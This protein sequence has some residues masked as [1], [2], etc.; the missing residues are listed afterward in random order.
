MTHHFRHLLA[1]FAR[2]MFGLM[3]FTQLSNI[4]QACTMSELD[5][6]AAFSGAAMSDCEDS[7]GTANKNACLFHCLQ[8]YQVTQGSEAPL[9]SPAMEFPQVAV[10]QVVLVEL[11]RVLPEPYFSVPSQCGERPLHLR[12]SRFLN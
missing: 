9:L 10:L 7:Q 2:L 8:D 5:P 12:F 3:L 1:L 11:P 6:A 4:A